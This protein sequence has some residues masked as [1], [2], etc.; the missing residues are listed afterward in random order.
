MGSM[1][2]S[3]PPSPSPT[4]RAGR[5]ELVVTGM[6]CAS[7]VAHVTKA[8]RKVPG[9]TEASVNLATER[10]SVAHGPTV[11]GRA[12]IAA[13][14]AA[15]YGAAVAESAGPEG[16]DQDAQRREAE[17]ARRRRLL[18][19]GI[20][21]SAPTV[22]LGMFAPAFPYKDWLM[23]AL[24]LPVWAIVGSD[25]HRGAISQARHGSANMDTL[26]SL[27]STA[28]LFYSFY[29]TVVGRPTYYETAAA[30]VTLIFVGKYLE[31]VARG[32]SNRAI[33]ALLSLRPMIARVREAD[34]AT[35]E[36]PV[37]RI[38]IG[39]VVIVPAG[40]RIPV[41]GIVVEGRSAVDASM[42]TGEP[43]PVEV[44]PGH[45]VQTGTLN[46]DG[47]LVVRAT[48]V[49]AGTVL[50]KIVEIV[51]QAQGSTPP[52]QR[53][54]DRV[55]AVFVPIVLALATLTWLAW[56][57][58]GHPWV[59]ALIAAVAVVVV[60]CP[61]A[62]GLA[63][64]MAIMVGVGIGAKRGVLFKDADALERLAHV[65]TVVFDKTG[66]LTLGR[67]ELLAIYPAPG[68]RE[69]DVLAVAAA[70]ER[71]SSHPLAKAIVGA[72]EARASVPRLR[73]SESIAMRGRG[74][75]AV[76]EGEEAF[77]GTAAFLEEAGID[78][79]ELAPLA[80]RLDARATR[81]F[82]AYRGKV[83]GALEMGDR[84]RDEA[85]EAV[86]ALRSLRVEA[87]LVSGDAPGAVAAVAKALKIAH[88]N[89]QVSP[90]RKGEIV[91]AFRKNGRTVAFVGDGI[92]DA[93][94]LA[95]ADVGFAMGSGTEI[96]METAQAAIISNDPRAVAQAIRLAR[97]T[98]RTVKQNLF[99]AFAYNIVLLPLAAA[100]VVQPIMAAAA[101][102]F[103]SLF[104][105]GNSLLLNRR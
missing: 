24:T 78:R 15:G 11:D 47:T 59:A 99:W 43:I 4:P 58:T 21:L 35:R 49:G 14:E 3:V 45:A 79:R 10:A 86:D 16:A 22:I 100:G 67:P 84:I 8:L 13:V 57:A 95:D 72:A 12:L 64:P 70:V 17:I 55:A 30:I 103:S 104:V 46:G 62:M 9:V 82:V 51:R 26:V 1:K 20:A 41:D 23:L 71:G 27:G 85:R 42:L 31:V 102:G 81:V 88:W 7:C 92:N 65:D 37:E 36:I 89:A 97:A 5:T 91:L 87:H 63:T 2:L 48:A 33:R 25:F 56:I 66:T 40:E 18:V 96:A 69:E 73:A 6:T 101:M 77:V 34:G 75:R 50:A 54:A 80:G 98:M 53:L 94:A 29:A 74:L 19:V 93:P 90:E 76:V 32:K 61:C 52:V 39:D 68:A 44:E 105:V 38:G 28:A 83:I 60:A